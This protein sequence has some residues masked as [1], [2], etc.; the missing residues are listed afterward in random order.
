MTAIAP[1]VVTLRRSRMAFLQ[2][3]RF[4]HSNSPFTLSGGRKPP[5]SNI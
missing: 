5:T 2:C 1:D 3:R 4:I